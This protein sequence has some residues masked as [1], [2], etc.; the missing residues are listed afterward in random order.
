MNKQLEDTVRLLT[1]KVH[2]SLL[3]VIGGSDDMNYQVVKG[4]MVESILRVDSSLD[5]KPRYRRQAF[6][7]G[8]VMY[9][10][11]HHLSHLRMVE[12]LPQVKHVTIFGL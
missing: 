10:D 3:L 4:S 7:D 6:K 2:H 9:E 11:F 12:N 5:V 1:S 8:P